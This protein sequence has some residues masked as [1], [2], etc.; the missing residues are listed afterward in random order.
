MTNKHGLITSLIL[1]LSFSPVMMKVIS[2]RS[3][4]PSIPHPPLLLPR[5]GTETPPTILMPTTKSVGR[6]RTRNRI[7]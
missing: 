6:G 4:P 2:Q 1:F 5:S 3:I 7:T